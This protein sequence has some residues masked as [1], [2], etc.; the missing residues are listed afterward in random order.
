MKKY[1]LFF[2]FF[3]LLLGGFFYYSKNYQ[4]NSQNYLKTN[5]KET[6]IPSAKAV[7]EE[8]K[9]TIKK[10]EIKKGSTFGSLMAKAGIDSRE[11]QEMYKNLK[12]IYN[13]TN[14]RLGRTFDFY[15][16]RKTD[17]LEKIV[18]QIDTQDNLEIF[19]K[20]NI[21]TGEIKK[22]NYEIKIK[23]GEGEVKT[24]MYQAA[25][26]GGVDERVIIALANAFQWT[27]DFAMDS[28][29]GDK[30]KVVYE[31]RYLDGK[32]VMPGRILAGKYINKGKEFKVFYFEEDENNKGYF[33]EEGN[34]VQKMFLRAPVEF[35]YISSGYTTGTRRV[36]EVGLVGRHRAID[37]AAA[38]GTPIRAVGDGVVTFAGWSSIGYGNFTKIRHNATYSTNYAHQSKIIVKVGQRVKQGQIIGYVGSTGYSTGPHLH[39]EMVKNGQKINPLKEVLPPGKPIKKENRARFFKEI[40]KYQ[41]LLN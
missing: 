33:D 19:K 38:I 1:I 14:I 39:F 18:Y 27:I 29:V 2:V 21:W 28:Q 13:L 10:F 25:K 7:S 41:K 20:D 8:K 16:N 6:I 3:L 22:I 24:S 11:A 4:K 23:T 30:F 12:D 32:Y 31:E 34:S 15:Y 36:M 37:Y 35:K 40:E 5:L 9:Y 26:D 17:A